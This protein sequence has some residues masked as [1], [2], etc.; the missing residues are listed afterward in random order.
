M[1][2]THVSANIGKHTGEA[3]AC[4]F[5][6]PVPTT[7]AV[8]IGGGSAQIGNNAGK[9]RYPIPYGF[10]FANHR[11][12]G[13]ALNYTAF[14]LGNGAESAA[15]EAAAHNGNRET[16]HL[17]MPVF[18]LCRIADEA[19]VYRETRTTDPVPL[20]SAEWAVD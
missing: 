18:W 14:V 8:H 5:D 3:P 9:S 15:A 7:Q 13:T 6:F 20:C 16:D 10:N 2:R 12:L 19:S 11:L 17:P 1:V 4:A